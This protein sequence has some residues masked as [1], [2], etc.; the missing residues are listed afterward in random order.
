[1]KDKKIFSE[2]YKLGIASRELFDLSR[3][4]VAKISGLTARTVRNIEAGQ[5]FTRDTIILYMYACG[6]GTV[7]VDFSKRG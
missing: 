3:E 6:V 2:I 4:D 7:T 1:M 5:G